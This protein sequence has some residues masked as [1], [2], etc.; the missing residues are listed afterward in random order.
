MVFPRNKIVGGWL[1]NRTFRP[2]L[3]VEIIQTVASNSFLGGLSVCA[4]MSIY[5]FDLKIPLRVEFLERRVV[6]EGFSRVA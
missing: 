5:S 2:F 1:E 3:Y 4:N 6:N